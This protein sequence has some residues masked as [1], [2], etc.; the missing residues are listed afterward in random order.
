MRVGALVYEAYRAARECLMFDFRDSCKVLVN[1]DYRP[2]GGPGDF[3]ERRRTPKVLYSILRYYK[4]IILG[5]LTNIHRSTFQ[6]NHLPE[7]GS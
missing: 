4:R 6:R 1:G 2:T 5:T 3:S 7:H